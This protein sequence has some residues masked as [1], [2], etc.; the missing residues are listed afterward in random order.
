MAKCPY[1]WNFDVECTSE[2][3][4]YKNGKCGLVRDAGTVESVPPSGRCKV[5]NL[6]YNP[7]TEKLEYDY[8]ETPT[9]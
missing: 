4:L 3:A 1:N 8:D 9:E 6:F 7:L 5:T 2:C